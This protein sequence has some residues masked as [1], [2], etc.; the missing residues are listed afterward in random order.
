MGLGVGRDG[1]LC[2]PTAANSTLLLA[3][4][5]RV[6]NPRAASSGGVELTRLESLHPG[7][8]AALPFVLLA[9]PPLWLL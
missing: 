2:S 6:Q 5:L 1:E 8:M 4:D 7:L 9:E 3:K